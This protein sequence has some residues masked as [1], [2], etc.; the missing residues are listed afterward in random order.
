MT[1]GS[2][3]LIRSVRDLA[4]PS[5]LG[6]LPDRELVER[7]ADRGDG[8][9]F[10]LLVRRHGPMVLGVCRRVLG[11]EQDAEDVFQAVFLVLSRKAGALR[12]KDAVGP[13]LFGVARRLALRARQKGRERQARETRVPERSAGD[14]ADELTVREAQEILDEEL[15]RLPERERG[16]IILCY[17]EGLT[18]DEA[19]A[20]LGCPLGTL[21]A[22]LERGRAVLEKRLARRGLG[23]PATLLVILPAGGLTAAVPPGLYTATIK[24][25]S[26][27]AAG[28]AAAAGVIPVRPAALAEGVLETMTRTKL[29][30]ALGVLAVVAV[31]GASAAALT[32]QAP[33]DKPAD[34]PVKEKLVAA[35]KPAEPR[36]TPKKESAGPPVT[37]KTEAAALPTVISGV[38]EAVDA[39]KNALTVTHRDGET[40]FRL[41]RDAKIDIDNKPGTLAGLPKGANVTLSQFVDPKTAGNLQAAGR[42]YFGA[43]VKAVDAGRN[44]ITVA[45]KEGDKTFAVAP[46][47]FILVDGKPRKLDGVPAG[48]FVNLGLG[49]DQATARSIGADG[50]YLGGC[51]GSLVKAVDAETG[52]ITFDDKAIAEVA[53][54]TFTVAKG[55]D[56]LLGG[57]P[58]TLSEVSAGSY[59]NLGL[60]VDRQLARQ[61]HVHGPPFLGDCGGSLVKAVDV[62]KGTITFDDKARAEIAG[63]TFLV[64]KDAVIVIDGKPGKLTSLP[65]GAYVSLRLTLD[66]QTAWEVFAQGPSA[67]CDCG[68]SLVRAVDVQNGT[69]TFDGKARAEVAGK[70]FAMARDALIQIDGKP[71]KL[72]E[73]PTGA[74]VSLTLSVDRQTVRQLNAN[75]RITTG[76]VRAV[77]ADKNTVNVDDTT[78]AVA[79]DA[80]IV[81]DGKPA[82]LVGLSTGA[83][84]HLHLRVDQQTVGMIQTAA[85]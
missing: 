1:S 79:K 7:F 52:T 17:L 70:T 28:Q 30:I 9:S 84:V 20:R 43:P 37:Q 11:H 23:L 32:Q 63:K 45:D 5:G 40:T 49:V 26:L 74:F 34:P 16:A 8:E 33:A 73:L 27:F 67:V 48:A 55:A 14:P 25:A 12:R 2:A 21:K 61:V 68:G 41:T 59:V 39:E 22:R 42:W 82:S 56:V 80:V 58:G 24:A 38:V 19:A 3:L 15:A 78:Y 51:G 47:A 6:G 83:N 10:A 77:D 65:T 72:T 69:I 4:E 81:I 64:A 31:L 35:D 71:G 44:T 57:K 53:G 60:T 13:W 36:A 54:K 29:K 46:D 66:G 50:P 18:R 75:G 76:V 62:E 85:R